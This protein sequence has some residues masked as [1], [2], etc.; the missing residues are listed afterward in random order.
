MG[1]QYLAIRNEL[2]WT[3]CRLTRLR[4]FWFERRLTASLVHPAWSVTILHAPCLMTPRLIGSRST[5]FS[6]VPSNFGAIC[7][8]AA[9]C[10]LGLGGNIPIDATILL[11]FL[12]AVSAEHR[13]TPHKIVH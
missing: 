3:A 11:E 6:G 10:G 12:P 7:A 8:L 13:I 4:D 2:L 1:V 5:F 9:L